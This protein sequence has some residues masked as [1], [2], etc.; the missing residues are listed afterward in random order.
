MVVNFCSECG[1]AVQ[2][3]WSVCPYCSFP[4]GDTQTKANGPTTVHGT[5]DSLYK[6]N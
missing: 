4:L 2:S 5:P 1:K 3:D 6:E